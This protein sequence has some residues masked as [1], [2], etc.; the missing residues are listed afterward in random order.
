M[1]P[2]LAWV[3]ALVCLIPAGLMAETA[4]VVSSSELQLQAAKRSRERQESIARV[5][6]FLSTPAARDALTKA[7]LDPQKIQ[8]AVPELNDQELTQLSV[9]CRASAERFRRR[10]F[11]HSK[12]RVNHSWS[13]SPSPHHCDRPDSPMRWPILASSLYLSLTPVEAKS[14]M[15][16]NVPF[17]GSATRGFATAQHSNGLLWYCRT[18]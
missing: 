18:H 4:H 15:W 2:T 6:T 3:L 12:H 11:E 14:A 17:C 8:T 13:C 10:L 9:P 1:R 7:H 16:L 5:L